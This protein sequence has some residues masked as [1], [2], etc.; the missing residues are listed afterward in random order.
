AANLGSMYFLGREDE[1]RERSLERRRRL[2]DLHQI[3]NGQDFTHLPRPPGEFSKISYLHESRERCPPADM[4]AI[5]RVRASPSGR[6]RRSAARHH[7]LRD[8]T[9]FDTQR[10]KSGLREQVAQVVPQVVGVKRLVQIAT[11]AGQDLREIR[12]VRV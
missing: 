2:A 9:R 11:E 4:T 6:P 8:E 1:T 7:H 10:S 3:R 5:T 12:S